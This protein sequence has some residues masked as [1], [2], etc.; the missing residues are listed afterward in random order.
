MVA[1]NPRTGP[2][3]R[4]L[5]VEQGIHA[6]RVT[7]KRSGDFVA[8]FFKPLGICETVSH[9]HEVLPADH[10]AA[11]LRGAFNGVS[12]VATHESV[13][14]WRP[15]EERVRMDATII[16]QV[17]GLRLRAHSSDKAIIPRERAIVLYEG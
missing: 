3:M 13:T 8:E 5:L 17:R 9:L 6:Q 2:Q 10:Y 7:R 1:L 4:T 16:F 11:Q 12:V 14:T 15:V